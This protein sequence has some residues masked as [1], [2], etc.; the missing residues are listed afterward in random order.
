MGDISSLFK[1]QL[2]AAGGQP[3]EQDAVLGRISRVIL[4]ATLAV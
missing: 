4:K 3:A 2:P 1:R